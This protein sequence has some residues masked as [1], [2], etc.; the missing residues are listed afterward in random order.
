M[1]AFISALFLLNIIRNR[2]AAVLIMMSLISQ[3]GEIALGMILP[4]RKYKKIY[5][6][7]FQDYPEPLG[8]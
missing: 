6:M 8:N 7:G 5:Q 2:T 4:F 3:Q 1:F